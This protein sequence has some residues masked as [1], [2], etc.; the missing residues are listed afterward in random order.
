MKYVIGEGERVLVF[1]NERLVEYLK[2][3]TYKISSL[4]NKK[5]G[6]IKNIDKFSNVILD[7]EEGIKQAEEKII[8]MKKTKNILNKEMCKIIEDE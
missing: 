8:T 2:S 7:L 4:S 5:Y 6:C 1:K 3:G